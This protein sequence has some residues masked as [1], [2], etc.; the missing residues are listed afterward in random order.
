MK[1]F[2]SDIYVG[3]KCFIYPFNKYSLYIKSKSF[4]FWRKSS[5]V[6]AADSKRLEG[7]ENGAEFGDIV[8]WAWG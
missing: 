5:L 8:P 6:H 4:G 3:L 7:E 2:W 1:M